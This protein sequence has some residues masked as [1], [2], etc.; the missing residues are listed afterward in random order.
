M[1]LNFLHIFL[2]FFGLLKIKILVLK[3]KYFGDTPPPL[4]AGGKGQWAAG[5]QPAVPAGRA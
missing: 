3:I 1:P 4:L 2:K 5:G